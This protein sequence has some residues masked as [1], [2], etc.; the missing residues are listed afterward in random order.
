M[1]FVSLIKDL[2]GME[3]GFRCVSWVLLQVLEPAWALRSPEVSS[4]GLSSR[5]HQEVQISEL[6]DRCKNILVKVTSMA[7]LIENLVLVPF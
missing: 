3:R 4:R 1:I 2:P 7:V 6:T 5:K